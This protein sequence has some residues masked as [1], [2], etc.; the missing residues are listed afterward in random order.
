MFWFCWQVEY[1]PV[2]H[3]TLAEMKNP[4]LFAERVRCTM[5]RAMNT[6]LTQHTYEDAALAMEA[7]KLK[8][9]SGSALLEFGQFKNIAPFTVKEAKRCLNKFVKMDSSKRLVPTW[10]TLSPALSPAFWNVKST[11]SF[12]TFVV[13]FLTVAY[14]IVAGV[15]WLTRTTSNPSICLIV[16][17][18]SRCTGTLIVQT[19]DTSIFV[20]YFISLQSML[21]LWTLYLQG[22]ERFNT[23]LQ[24]FLTCWY[25]GTVRCR[26]CL[27]RWSSKI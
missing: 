25:D 11:A 19:M 27:L 24:S 14:A 7:V 21:Y 26:N 17:S 5:A 9:N 15:L 8:I 20:R 3:P 6:S 18:Y 13:L 10:D 22:T 1:L 4:I 2:M 16:P 23:P 12:L